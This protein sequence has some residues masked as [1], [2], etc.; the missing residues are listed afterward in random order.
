MTRTCHQ[1]TVDQGS[2]STAVR[3]EA[4]CRGPNPPTI[5]RSL[6]KAADRKKERSAVETIDMVGETKMRAKMSV[7]MQ[8]RWDG[9]IM[10]GKGTLSDGQ[11]KTHV[12]DGVCWWWV[13]PISR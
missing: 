6:F 9:V 12:G 8:S 7:I 10:I 3:K 5:S 2:T 13:R 11:S 1:A 4:W